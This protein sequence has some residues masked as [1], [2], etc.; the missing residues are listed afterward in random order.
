MKKILFLFVLL[1]LGATANAQL[2]VVRGRTSVTHD[3]DSVYVSMR[4]VI[5]RQRIPS[6][7]TL[8]YAPAIT[9]GKW[10]VSL[11][12]IVVRGRRAEVAWR[13]HE[14][15]SDM[16]SR[17]AGAYH[18]ESGE[19]VEYRASVPF[20]PWM[21]GARIELE[22]VETGCGEVF[23]EKSTLIGRIIPPPP[24]P[25]PVVVPPPPP[26]PPTI[27]E[28]LAQTF[29]FVLPAS[30]FDPDEP[31]RFYEDERDNALTVYYHINKYD[32]D[33]DYDDNRHTLVNMLAAID[34]ITASGE[35]YVDKVVVAGFA[36]PEGPFAFN[37]R[38]AWDRA[39]SVKEYV[40]NNA[41]MADESILVFNGSLDWW[42]MR[43]LVAA[44]SEIPYKEEILEII[45]SRSELALKEQGRVLNRLRTLG[46]GAVW[47]YVAERIF[48][49]LRNGAFIRV[50]F[51]EL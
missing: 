5:P 9:G 45:D 15:A 19:T 29:P 41:D 51:D 40:M 3:G 4:A 10:K 32:I 2:T 1:F 48:P 24:P 31:I 34:A 22:T 33:P 7:M 36:S 18:A 11:P 12:A 20:Q 50:Y 35:V 43:R 49:R 39:V 30:E 28:L 13:R 17:N 23:V 26:T 44:D 25:L 46:D 47:D 37:D 14:W 38:L 6:G 16:V 42:G 27:G 8:I 21:Q